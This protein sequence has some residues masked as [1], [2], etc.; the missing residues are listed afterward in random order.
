M[1]AALLA[2]ALLLALATP[3]QAAVRQPAGFNAA[4]I[5]SLPPLYHYAYVAEA[6]ATGA[7]GGFA[8]LIRWLVD[9]FP[10]HTPAGP[11][12]SVVELAQDAGWGGGACATDRAVLPTPGDLDSCGAYAPAANDWVILRSGV[13]M[14]GTQFGLY[15]ELDSTTAIKVLLFPLDNQVAAPGAFVSPPAFPAASIGA[16]AATPVSFTVVN[17]AYR[18]S[19]VAD[20]AM[21]QLFADGAAKYW[22]Y[23]GELSGAKSDGT[24]ADDRPFAIW[25]TPAVF[26]SAKGVT[27]FNRI[28]PVDDATELTSGYLEVGMFSSTAGGTRDAANSGDPGLLGVWPIVPLAVTFRDVGGTH[29][30]GYLRGV[31]GTYPADAGMLV[32]NADKSILGISYS[33]IWGGLALNWDGATTYTGAAEVT[34]SRKGVVAVP[35]DQINGGSW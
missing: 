21:L 3:A 34:F 35:R 9:D 10:G 4:T 31:I 2:L 1:R 26:S 5:A 23:I 33:A 32:Q 7:A 17:G 6:Q 28:S 13:G 8:N 15:L 11:G 29:I 18:M 25:D 24:P 30:A 12:W 14:Y 16:G 27:N 19:A 22:M 20:S